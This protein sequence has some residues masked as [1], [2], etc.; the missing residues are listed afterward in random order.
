VL[1]A[2]A[3]TELIPSNKLITSVEAVLKSGCK[4]VQYRDKSNNPDKRLTEAT[5]LLNLCDKYSASLLINDDAHLAHQISAHGVHL[6]QHD[7]DIIAV[8]KLLGA[9]YIIGVT[10]HDSLALAEKAIAEGAN[11]ISFGRFFLSKTKPGASSA[12]LNILTDARKQFPNTMIVAI[13]GITLENANEVLAAGADI[14]AVCNSLFTAKD[15]EEQAS[16]FF[17]IKK[18]S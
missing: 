4:L 10:C 11:Y 7:D 17:N 9:D 6:G 15:V 1:Y 16:L 2:I 13:G 5:R 18:I 14:I 8:R 3:D 12:P